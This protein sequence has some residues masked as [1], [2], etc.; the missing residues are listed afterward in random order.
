MTIT[1]MTLAGR[2]VFTVYLRDITERRQAEAELRAYREQLEDLVSRRTLAL[3]S[4]EERLVTAINTFKGGFALYDAEERL[5]IANENLGRFMPEVLPHV[6]I[7]VSMEA[8]TRAIAAANGLGEDWIRERLALYRSHEEFTAQRQLRNGQ[9]IET[10]VRHTPD[11][12]TLFIITDISQHK[13]AEA[14][15]RQSLAREKELGQLQ[16]EFVSMTSHEFRTPL[17]IIDASIQRILRRRAQLSSTDFDAL[18]GEIR[19]AV[20]RMVGLIDTILD[21]SR[22]DSGTIQF[23]PQPCDL[24]Q[25]ITDVCKRQQALATRHRIILDLARLPDRIIADAVF[26]DQITTNLLTNAVK[27]SPNGGDVMVRGWTESG[28]VAFSF[29]DSGVG[30]PSDELARLF[31]RFFRARTSTGIA[32]TGIGLYIVKRLLDMHHG[33][34]HVASKEGCGSTITVRLPVVEMPIG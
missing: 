28:A 21:T 17:A 34:I 2:K 33:T 30:I 29:T 10:S 22:I 16:R 19:A 18:G 24:R 25:A 3:V 27:Y 9:W 11:G 1:E 32:G 14:A 13:Q 26:M 23:N 31:Q 20:T 8:M 6:R 15:L 12:S 4:A 5:S 7:G